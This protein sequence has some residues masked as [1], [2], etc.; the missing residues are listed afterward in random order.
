MGAAVGLYSVNCAEWV[1]VEGALT[2]GGLVSVPLYDTLGPDAVRYICTHAEL[3][4]VACHAAVLGTL[5]SQLVSCPTVRLV[6]VFG[7]AA[8][9]DAQ[10]PPPGV[11]A[12]GGMSGCLSGQAPGSPTA[13]C[14]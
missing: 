14:R 5:L 9:A 7:T 11:K 8:Q 10:T 4:A 1:L 6:I 12:R 2:R 3:V 13:Q